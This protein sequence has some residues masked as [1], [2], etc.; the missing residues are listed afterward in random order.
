MFENEQSGVQNGMISFHP[1]FKLGGND[2]FKPL[3]MAMWWLIIQTSLSTAKLGDR[4]TSGIVH[5]LG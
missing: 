3:A 2:D 5:D 4:Q 1:R